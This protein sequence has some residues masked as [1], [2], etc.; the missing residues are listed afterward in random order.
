MANLD[1][2]VA[3][4]TGAAQGIGTATAGLLASRGAKVV[5]AD[6]Q[7]AAAE[8]EANKIVAEGG[9][10]IAVDLDL[11]EEDSIKA[12]IAATLDA[13]GRI[14]VLNNNA[15][16]QRPELNAR[17]RDVLTME[18]DAWDRIFT[19]NLRGTMLCCKYALPTMLSQGGGSIINMASN[20]G[21]IIQC[22]YAASKAAMIQLTRSI[23][24][25]YGKDGIR[26]NSVAPGL[27]LAKAARENL[28]PEFRAIIEAETLTPFLGEPM[29][30]AYVVAFLASD[31]ARYITGHNLVADGGTYAHIPG[32]AALRELFS[33]PRD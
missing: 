11:A 9:A 24:T 6:I 13:F 33:R 25:A 27:T 22:A 16:D 3:I 15:A 5:L 2:K 30:I 18:T 17:A 21:N 20:L 26:C 32:F 29:D 7:V 12:L 10:A 1:G 23:A 4:V 19:V 8:R 14:D 31:E 28:T